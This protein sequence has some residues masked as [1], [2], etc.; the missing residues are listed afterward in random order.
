MCDS[1]EL[2]VGYLYGELDDGERRD[3]DAHLALCDECREEVAALGAT[4]GL[5]AMWTPPQADLALRVVR[6]ESAPVRP[7]A[8]TWPA[9][10][11]AAAA[12]LVLG[13]SAAIANLEI[14]YDATGLTVRTGWNRPAEVAVAPG[15]VPSAPGDVDLASLNQ[16]LLDIETAMQRASAPV[17]AT[18]AAGP[19]MSDAELLRRVRQLIGD[20]ETRQQRELAQVLAQV[21][22]DF[23][24]ARRTDLLAIQQGLGQYQGM[25][26]AEI[27]QQRDMLN[28]FIRVAAGREK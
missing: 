22:R 10:A 23:D 15:A 7:A 11:M 14:R 25:T 1:K 6:S 27:A 19:R 2:L 3:F 9:W 20:A 8:R 26:N 16:R 24:R 13:V 28:Q 21:V 4:R 18:D 12:M 17:A 5:V